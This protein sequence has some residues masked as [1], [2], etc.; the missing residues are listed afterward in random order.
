MNGRRQ[1]RVLAAE[2][3]AAASGRYLPYMPS[4]VYGCPVRGLSV[5]SWAVGACATGEGQ[6]GV[7]VRAMP[8]TSRPS[9]M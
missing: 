8:K 5:S 3:R 2:A 9:P 4:A 6:G 1:T 7:S